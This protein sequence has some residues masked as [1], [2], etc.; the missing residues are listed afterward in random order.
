MRK[1]QPLVNLTKDLNRYASKLVHYT[2]PICKKEYD[3]KAG[4]I[5]FCPW[6]CV[7]NT[8]TTAGVIDVNS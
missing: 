1:S 2:C 3:L 7:V 8:N 6:G 5:N 4:R